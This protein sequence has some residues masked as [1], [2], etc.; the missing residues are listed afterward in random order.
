MTCEEI[1]VDDDLISIKFNCLKSAADKA[2]RLLSSKNKPLHYS[3]LC[4]E[5]NLLEQSL[6]KTSK[7]MNL[8]FLRPEIPI[9]DIKKFIVTT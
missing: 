8:Q 2:Y 5:I 9:S 1:E 7:L 6:S 4:K 3:E